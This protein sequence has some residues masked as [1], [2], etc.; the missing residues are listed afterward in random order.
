MGFQDRATVVDND[1]GRFRRALLCEGEPDRVPFGELGIEKPVKEAFL[2]RPIRSLAD[3]VAFWVGAGYDYVPLDQGLHSLI[4]AGSSVRGGGPLL[5]NHEHPIVRV[6]GGGQARAV[7]ET[8]ALYDNSEHERVWQ[9]EHRNLITSRQEFERFPW[10][11]AD[12]FDYSRFTT[13]SKCLPPQVKIVAVL[14]YIFSA[15]WQLMGFEAF[16]YALQEDEELI[17]LTFERVGT[18]QLGVLRRMLECDAVGAVGHPDDMAYATSLMVSPRVLRRYVFPWYE[19]IASLCRAH[20]LPFILHSDG[21]L[22]EV[23]DDLIACGVNALHPIEPKAMDIRELKAR[24]RGRLCL[25]GNIDIGGV[26]SQGS[27]AEVYEDVREHLRD[28]AP[29]GGYCL[30]SSNS[31]TGFVPFENYLALRQANLE[32]G[33][34]PIRL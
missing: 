19:E 6:L 28:L 34:Y 17:R 15:V 27:P 4:E 10:P 14:G 33:G 5:L 16:C 23:I 1:F 26:L 24:Y 25:I 2:G 31:I 13:V 18:I 30:S 9:A 32:L 3:E 12:D 11:D 29:G 20:G 21:K 7:Q 22:T 8:Y